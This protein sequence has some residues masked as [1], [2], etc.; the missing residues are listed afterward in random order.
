MV[1]R[2][3]YQ[4]NFEQF[5]T[6]VSQRDYGNAY[7]LYRDN[8]FGSDA[9]VYLE[10]EID[11]L[12]LKYA[13]NTITAEELSAALRVLSNFPT[14][15][16]NL[17]TAQVAASKL[18]ASKNAYVEGKE[19]TDTYTRLNLWRQVVDLDNVNYAAVQQ[20]IADN[21][22][23]YAADLDGKITY[24]STRVRAFATERYEVLAYW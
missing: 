5:C 19:S 9:D 2:I 10:K 7:A 13:D 18:E 8:N 3:Q 4:Q 17:L 1:Q 6:Y 14:M 22:D 20:N 12:I 16:Q 11:Q 23:A 21:A 15:E 24:Y